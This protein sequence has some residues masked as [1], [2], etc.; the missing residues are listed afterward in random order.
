MP[1]IF[2]AAL[3]YALLS[4]SAAAAEWRV[5]NADSH[6]AFHGSMLGVPVTGYFTKFESRI[7]FDPDDLEGAHLSI[8]IDMTAVNTAHEE[9]DTAL[10]LPEWFAV[11]SYAQAEFTATRFR[12]T[13][14]GAFEAIGSL[15]V[16]GMKKDITLPFSLA[17]DGDTAVV[18]GSIDL[19]RRDFNIGDG[20][21]ADD[22]LVAFDVRVEF[23]IVAAR[24]CPQ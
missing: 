24:V 14:D 4:Q 9:R 23:K 3:L 7:D 2:I 12:R 6:I 17:I 18:S 16:K 11:Q 22:R 10:K 21:W 8:L 1:R 13:G 15:T 5:A 19:N 20:D